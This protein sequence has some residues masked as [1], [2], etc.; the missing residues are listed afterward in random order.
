MRPPAARR[1]VVIG[2]RREGGQLDPATSC[3]GLWQL[4]VQRRLLHRCAPFSL[5]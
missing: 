1:V 5:T 3:F 2:Q 4:P